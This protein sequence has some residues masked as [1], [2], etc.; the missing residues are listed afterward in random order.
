MK[1]ISICLLA[2]A[3]AGN[4]SLMAQQQTRGIEKDAK[5]P[6]TGLN[7]LD[8][9]QVRFFENFDKA[10]REIPEGW[11]ETHTSTAVPPIQW[12]FDATPEDPGYNT[13]P[14]SLNYNDGTDFDDGSSNS[15]TVTTPSIDITGLENV[16][17]SFY[18]ARQT[19]FYSNGGPDGPSDNSEFDVLTIDILNSDGSL[20]LQTIPDDFLV[21]TSE[22]TYYYIPTALEV[23]EQ[24]Q[25]RIRFNFDTGDDLFNNGFGVFIDDLTVGS[26]QM[27][28]GQMYA[29]TGQ[30]G[31]LLLVSPI[32]GAALQV[33][34]IGPATEVE[35]DSEGNIYCAY[36]GGFSLIQRI[37]PQT[38]STEVVG[39]H[40]FGAMN[41]MEFINGVLYGA[42]YTPGQ[43]TRLVIINTET[44][45]ITEVGTFDFT[46]P[47]T[48]L[49]WNPQTNEL[50]GLVSERNSSS[51]LILIDPNDASYSEVDF[52]QVDGEEPISLRGLEFGDNGMLYSGTPSY[53]GEGFPGGLLVE[54]NPETAAVDIIGP[55]GFPMISGVTASPIIPPV[56]LSNWA[57]VIALGLI[58]LGIAWRFRRA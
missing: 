41:G 51:N 4:L 2:I 14:N 57:V 39:Q 40:P 9:K 36:G 47:I 3:L 52:C 53:E 38:Q 16:Y 45:Q 26:I 12:D 33:M 8:F 24:D 25:I 11:S 6:L 28:E 48:G 22:W 7:V 49:A 27:L 10:S 42:L 23:L 37:N 56:P 15:G 34:T 19:E 35:A 29:S 5:S 32:S 54:I 43:N 1:K 44:A 46:Y 21:P 17:L 30:F 18:Y 13:S 58:G 20:I 55:T 50:F 31:A